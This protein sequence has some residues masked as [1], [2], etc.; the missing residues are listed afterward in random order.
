VGTYVTTSTAGERVRAFVPFPLPPDPPLLLAPDDLDLMERANRSLGKL[1]GLATLLPEASLF[2]Y[3]YVR[4]EAVLS[5]QIEGT[6][7]SFADLL[8]YEHE[9]S[10]GVP[11]GD[12]EEVSSYVAAMKHGLDRLRGGFPLSLRLIREIHSILL[13]HGRGSDRLPG[14]FRRSQNWI[15]GTRPGNARFVP[16][17]PDRLPDCLSDLERFLHGKPVRMPVL[18]RAALV[19]VQFETIHPF[20]DGNGRLGR[21][22]V[23]LLLCQESVLSEPVLY[24]SLFFKQHRDVYYEHLQRVRIEGDWEGWVR[25][26][27][28]GVATT[29]DEGVAAARSILDMFAEHRCSIGALGRASGTSLRVHDLLQ[30]KPVVSIADVAGALDV[31][32]P[33]AAGALRRLEEIGFVREITGRQ[34]DRL[35]VYDPYVRLLGQGTE[36]IR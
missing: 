29:A 12:V 3:M 16:P 4:K 18:L 36:P 1:D 5:S 10:P 6:Q 34:R 11:V 33:T 15:G 26:F 32:A 23:A 9:Q 31:S 19:H 27:M 17:P 22:L 13:A 25:F 30:R 28:E 35:F 7:S 2:L 21:L 14:E 8:L 24:L 20:L